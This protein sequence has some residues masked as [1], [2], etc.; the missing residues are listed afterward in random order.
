MLAWILCSCSC[1]CSLSL[2]DMAP[3]EAASASRYIKRH[4]SGTVLHCSMKPERKSK[5]EG[6]FGAAPAEPHLEPHQTPKMVPVGRA[7]DFLH[8]ARR[9]QLRL[10]PRAEPS[11]IL[12]LKWTREGVK[13]VELEK[14]SSTGPVSI[15]KVLQ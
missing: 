3:P 8:G 13:R 15:S 9:S 5:S 2:F 1:K 4:C 6:L 10:R 12:S 14:S 7:K 11:H